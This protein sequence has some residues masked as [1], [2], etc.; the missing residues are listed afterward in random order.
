MSDEILEKITLIVFIVYI[1]IELKISISVSKKCYDQLGFWI[2]LPKWTCYWSHFNWLKHANYT[3]CAQR[4]LTTKYQNMKH[5][6]KKH[7]IKLRGDEI[8]ILVSYFSPYHDQNNRCK[9]VSPSVND[10]HL[11]KIWQVSWEWLSRRNQ[12]GKFIVDLVKVDK[13]SCK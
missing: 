9:N 3:V 4:Q 2:H 1:V 13:R 11:Q 7:W 5:F 12:K 6:K 8:R 10:L